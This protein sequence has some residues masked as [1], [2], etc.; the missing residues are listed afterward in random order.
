MA[1]LD[2]LGVK[3]TPEEDDDEIYNGAMDNASGVASLLESAR[4]LAS[5]PPKR[6][7][8]FIAVTA[9]EKGLN[10]SDYFARNPTVPTDNI[11]AVVNLD[12]PILN[13]PFAD[14]V[15][16]GAERSTLYSPVEQAAIAHEL[17]FSPDPVPEQG[18]FTRSDHYMFVRQGVP[19]VYI[20]PGFA[21]GG[22][23]AQA[24]FRGTHYHEPSDETA[25]MDFD[26]L[27]RF[28]DVNADIARNI[29]N[30]PERPV[31]NAGDFFGS[32]FHGPQ[33]SD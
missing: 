28:T 27:R 23:E 18:L 9:E 2:H 20:K 11:V 22:E 15:A 29:A 10:G 26:S 13:Y 6:S 4:M 33:A 1:H 19:A 5:S 8:I 12:M 7:V 25:L 14:I 21:N 17:Q 24:T 3:P 32:T 31:W 16:F 30:M